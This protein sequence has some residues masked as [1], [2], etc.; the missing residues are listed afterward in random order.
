MLWRSRR[1]GRA[2]L[3]LHYIL[4]S[5]RSV[6]A[7]LFVAFKPG[8]KPGQAVRVFGVEL[9][10][11]ACAATNLRVGHSNRSGHPISLYKQ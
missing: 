9:S 10:I 5:Q 11:L 8:F 6:G 3:S 1:S 4:L 2:I 7:R